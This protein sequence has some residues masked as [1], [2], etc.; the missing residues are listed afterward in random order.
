VPVPQRHDHEQDEHD[1]H[2][3]A[4]K[5]EHPDLPRHGLDLPAPGSDAQPGLIGTGEMP[6]QVPG[7][8]RDENGQVRLPIW[9]IGP[10]VS[11]SPCDATACQLTVRRVRARDRYH[12]WRMVPCGCR[13]GT[14]REA[15]I[16]QGRCR[17]VHHIRVVTPADATPQVVDFLV[18]EFGVRNLVVLPGAARPAGDAVQFDVTDGSANTVLQ[19]LGDLSLSRASHVSVA[20]VDAVIGEGG[21]RTYHGEIPVVWPIVESRIRED[22]GTLRVSSPCWR[23]R[24]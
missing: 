2:Q 5:Q 19:R 4:P 7:D 8:D 17:C 22:A 20:V 1:Q 23:S 24:A 6:H 16:R 15:V 14:I 11:S 10:G 12:L 18:V 13:E 9:G 21:H 3:D